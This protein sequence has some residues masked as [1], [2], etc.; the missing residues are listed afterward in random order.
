MYTSPGVKIEELPARGPIVPLGT[1]TAAFVG[2]TLMGPTFVPRKVTNFSQFRDEFGGVITAP[3]YFMAPAV[4]G[5]FANGGRSAWV[6]RVGTAA[7]ATLRLDDRNG[8]TSLVVEARRQA[9][10][11]TMIAETAGNAMRVQVRDAS[12]ARTTAARPTA[13]VARG[14][15]AQITVASAADAATFR[16]GDI[17]TIEGTSERAV[18]DRVRGIDIFLT[19]PLAQARTGGTLRIDTLAAGQRSFRVSDPSGLEVGSSI[20]VTQERTTPDETTTEDAIVAA[21]AGDRITLAAPLTNAY[22]MASA[23]RPVSVKSNEF[24]LVIK[25]DGFLND[26][27]VPNLAMDPRHSRFAPRAATSI[28][29]IVRLPDPPSAAEPPDNRPRASDDDDFTPLSGGEEDDRDALEAAHYAQGLDALRRVDDINMVAIPDRFDATVQQAMIAHCEVMSDRFAVLDPAPGSEPLDPGGILDQRAMVE[30]ARGFAALYY[31]RIVVPDIAGGSVPVTVPPSG[32]LMGIYARVDAARGVH[33]AP[34]N[35]L[36]T[37]ALALERTLTDEELGEL[38]VAGIN[39]IRTFPNGARP[40]VWG[41]RT[42]A[43]ALETP[44]RYINVRRLLLS[45]EETIQEAL[46]SA[47]FEPNTLSLWKRLDRTLTEYLTRVWK[48]GAL[49]GERPEHAFYVKIDEELNPESIR[50]MGQLVIEIGVAP[51]RP[52]EF[53]IV[54]IGLWEGGGS[55]AEI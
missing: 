6:V 19:F 50:A 37:G 26:E 22:S 29:V 41:A 27:R 17:V 23:A 4:Y 21:V 39:V 49:F 1:S 36:I 31:P 45:L 33:K 44:F 25:R 42:T 24:D 52:A 3:R 47:I 55:V 16:P 5:F 53:I 54:R 43:P 18:V 28:H 7:T 9:P 11:G 2:P 20:T 8:G 38:N 35:E 34:A 10:N 15:S 12:I 32:H 30:S 13:T 48:A 40:V 46:R 14:Q 51:T